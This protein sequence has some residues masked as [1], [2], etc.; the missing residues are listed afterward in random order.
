MNQISVISLDAQEPLDL[1]DTG[2]VMY[3]VIRKQ[4]VANVADIHNWKN[5][6]Q[7]KYVQENAD[8]YKTEAQGRFENIPYPAKL[9]ESS[10]FPPDAYSQKQF[11]D[12]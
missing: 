7:I 3:H 6:I 2:F 9:C 11:K 1:K 12:W 10:D 5:Y 4:V 8:W